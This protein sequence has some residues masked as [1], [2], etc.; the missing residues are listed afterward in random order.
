[1]NP[2]IFNF[3]LRIIFIVGLVFGIHLLALDYLELELFEN[4]IVLAYLVNTF[5]A[6][7]TYTALFLLRNR[8]KNQLGFLF[9]GGSG[10]KFI[11]FFLLFYGAYKADGNISTTE[12]FAFFI[13]YLFTLII[14]IFSLSKWLNKI[15]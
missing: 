15:E 4:K 8:F 7:V 2:L 12:F 9:I 14:E 1:M 10:I 3:L 13:P 6:I 11:L 5:L